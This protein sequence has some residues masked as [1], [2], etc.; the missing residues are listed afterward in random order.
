MKTKAKYLSCL[1]EEM[2]PH[3]LHMFDNLFPEVTKYLVENVANG[4]E[5]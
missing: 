2:K 1:D 4:V 5:S 3:H